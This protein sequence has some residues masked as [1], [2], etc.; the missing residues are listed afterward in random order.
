ML[1]DDTKGG[2]DNPIDET[3]DYGR[4]DNAIV[5]Q[6]IRSRTKNV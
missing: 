1:S 6:G 2:I 5:A 4:V 3:R